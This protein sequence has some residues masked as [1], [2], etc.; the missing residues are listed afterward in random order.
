MNIQNKRPLSAINFPRK[1][2]GQAKALEKLATSRSFCHKKSTHS[3][4]SGNSFSTF[5]AAY[6]Q[7]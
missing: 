7:E 2:P 1:F 6:A 5:G 4:H 3:R